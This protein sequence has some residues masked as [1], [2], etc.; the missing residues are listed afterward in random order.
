VHRRRPNAARQRERLRI[1]EEEKK[2][3]PDNW[4]SDESSELASVCGK[5]EDF[6]SERSVFA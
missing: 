6:V 4:V 2:I 5:V 1:L 3:G